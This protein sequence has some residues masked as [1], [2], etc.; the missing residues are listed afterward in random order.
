MRTDLAVYRDDGPLAALIGSRLARAEHRRLGWL[1]PPLL[2]AVEY[3]ALIAITVLFEPAALPAC[4]AL[5]AAVA[6]HH[7]DTVYRLRHQRIGPPAWLCLAGG[8]WEIRLLVAA[9]LAAIGGLGIGMTVAA[10]ALGVLYVAESVAGWRRL[11]QPA[12]HY[13]DEEGEEE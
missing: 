10:I 9:V 13:E 5:L 2:R 3:G 7:Y 12:V 1:V 8:G 4:F 6:F 11:R